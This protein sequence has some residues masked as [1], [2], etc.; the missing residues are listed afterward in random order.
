[1]Y[2]RELYRA[3]WA[4]LLQDKAMIFLSGPRQSGKTTLGHLIADTYTNSLYF[5]WDIPDHRKDL[6]ENPY[7]FER[8]QRKDTSTP[9]IILDEIH[10]FSKWKNYLKGIYDKYYQDYQFLVSGSG[11]LDIYQRGGDSLAGRYLLFHLCPFTLAELSNKRLTMDRFLE[12][13]LQAV[14]FAEAAKLWERLSR[15]SGFPEPYISNNTTSYKRWSSIY[16]HALIRE[17]IRDLSGIKSVYD[18]ETL[19]YL[20]PEKVG[21]PLSIPSLSRHLQV[22]YNTISSWLRLFERFYLSFSITPWT[23]K[24]TRAIRKERKHYL[25]DI[26]RIKDEASRFENMI[27]LE[28]YRAVTLWTDSGYGDFSLHFV[29][30]KE[31]REVD[32]LI[33]LER[34]PF[35]LVETKLKHTSPSKNL[36]RFQKMLEVP[37]VQLLNTGNSFQLIRNGEHKILIAPAYMWL[38]LLP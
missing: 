25:W 17:D 6:I 30:D 19:F 35:L 2:A 1:M 23:A 27:A 13:P 8:V 4:D 7:F 5:N 16:A 34:T 18:I 3:V 15:M 14:D 22:A 31:K 26:P 11:R 24:V 12:N 37:A 29:R 20:L 9:L 33:S 36:I 10:K 32:F 21:S 28:L 38:P